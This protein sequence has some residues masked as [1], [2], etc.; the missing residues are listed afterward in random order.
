MRSRLT[1]V[2]F[3]LVAVPVSAATFTVTNTNDLGPGSLRQAILDANA[4]AGADTIAF[5]IGA[6]P[7]TILPVSALPSITGTVNID[8]TTQPVYAGAPLIEIS[9]TAAPGFTSGLW[10]QAN[11]TTVT[12][13]SITGFTDGILV[14]AL[15]VVLSSNYVGLRPDGVTALPNL[16]GVQCTTGCDFIDIV[17]NVISGN[18]SL[19]VLLNGAS[20]DATVR[21]NRIG[22]DSTGLLDRG[23]NVGVD[24]R[25]GTAVIGG[26]L[27][28]IFGNTISGNTL[29]GIVIESP[30]TKVGV[31]GN[32]IG[33]GSDGTTP[34]GNGSHGIE[35]STDASVLGIVGAG[36]VI[37]FNGGNGIE[38]DTTG[39]NTGNAIR[40]NSI[41]ANT[42]LGIGF[43]GGIVVPNDLDDVDA[44]AANNL[45]NHP[46]LTSVTFGG[47][48]VT[49][50]G[51]LNSTP[52]STFDIDFFR[53]AACDAS[54]FGEGQT[55]LGTATVATNANGDAAINTVL[56]A[57]AGGVITATATNT[58]TGDTSQFSAC[59]A[60]DAAAGEAVP[61]L[62][63]WALLL[64]ASMIGIV[65]LRRL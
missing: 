32:F 35:V 43:G 26:N 52:S 7:Q 38:I 49:I 25:S 14:S 4:A 48:N 27:P 60:A 63:E 22:T 11:G 9:G 29:S 62:S 45:Q 51:T 31:G 8:G 41:F 13:L 53:N 54:G 5:S 10:I 39:A 55:Y 21:S 64:L 57:A 65:A 37:A 50:T 6:G 1:F 3:A 44:G 42:Q 34:I 33:L 47:G 30:S 17:G 61:T 58:A 28:A 23:N 12:G 15:N 40:G 20:T 46:V 18:G 36:N 56:P 59:R 24:V 16:N 2:L 19:G